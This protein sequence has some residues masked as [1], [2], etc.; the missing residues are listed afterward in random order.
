MEAGRARVGASGKS[1]FCIREG[2]SK[3]PMDMTWSKGANKSSE[4]RERCFQ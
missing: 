2:K 1:D 4:C 3:F